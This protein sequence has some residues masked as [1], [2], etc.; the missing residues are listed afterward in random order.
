M[1]TNRSSEYMDKTLEE[2]IR[3]AGLS[4]ELIFK[5][6]PSNDVVIEDVVMD[7]QVEEKFPTLSIEEID[8]PNRWSEISENDLQWRMDRHRMPCLVKSEPQQKQ[9]VDLRSKICKRKNN[10][11]DRDLRNRIVGNRSQPTNPM[12]AF[13]TEF[14]RQFKKNQVSNGNQLVSLKN[15]SNQIN[16]AMAV[17]GGILSSIT[18]TPTMNPI[19]AKDKKIQSE[20]A[21]LQRKKLVMNKNGQ[22]TS[23]ANWEP[24]IIEEGAVLSVHSTNMLLHNRFSTMTPMEVIL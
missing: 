2:Y 7:E 12:A 14:G 17:I 20:I 8:E 15:S 16:G 4:K 19:E 1:L 5:E 18:P 23:S 13:L 10:G 11:N 6:E 24:E 21:Q 22:I 3:D 9:R